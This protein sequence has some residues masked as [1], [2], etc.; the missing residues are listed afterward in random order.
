VDDALHAAMQLVREVEN[1]ADGPTLLKAA[2]DAHSKLAAALAF[3]Q[4]AN[5]PVPYRPSTVVKMPRPYQHRE[6]E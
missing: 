6:G 5:E 3:Q 4:R 2:H 1:Y